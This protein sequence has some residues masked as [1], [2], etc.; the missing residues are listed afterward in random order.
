M[1]YT[2]LQPTGQP[3]YLVGELSYWETL[4]QTVRWVFIEKDLRCQLL[5]SHIHTHALIHEVNIHTHTCN[6]TWGGRHM[7]KHTLIHEQYLQT[8]QIQGMCNVDFDKHF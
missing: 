3:D 8:T 2:S 4:T 7:H 6:N 5:A 1:G